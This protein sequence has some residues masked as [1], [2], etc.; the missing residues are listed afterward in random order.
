MTWTKEKDL[1]YKR[2]YYKKRREDPNYRAH[3]NAYAREWR[4]KKRKTDPQFLKKEQANTRRRWNDPIIRATQLSKLRERKQTD[5]EFIARGILNAN[6][7]FAKKNGYAPIDT[8]AE[9]LLAWL[10]A[11][12]AVCPICLQD[13]THPLSP[14]KGRLQVDHDHLTGKL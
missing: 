7:C 2:E 8:T 12:K 9:E 3:E 10:Q 1:A 5:P 4:A 14:G 6:R 13:G 11:Q